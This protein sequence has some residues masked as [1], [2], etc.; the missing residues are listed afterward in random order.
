MVSGI[1]WTPDLHNVHASYLIKL[2]ILASITKYTW[3]HLGTMN[4]IE[5][6]QNCYE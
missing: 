3:V 6:D 4:P 1:L 2:S 5:K